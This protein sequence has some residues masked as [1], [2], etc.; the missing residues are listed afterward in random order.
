[1][2][3]IKMTNKQI[4]E[5]VKSMRDSLKQK[6]CTDGKITVQYNLPKYETK[7]KAIVHFNRPAW[8]K[9]KALVNSCT[10][11][12]GWHGTVTREDSLFT[13]H[14]VFVFPQRV[15]GTT[16]TSD[17]TKYSLWLNEQPDEV[18][19]TLRFHG[20][21]HV[22][23]GVTP[24]GVDTTYQED[25]LQ[26]I[27][28]FYM[29]GIFNKRNQVYLIIYDVENNIIYDD[30]DILYESDEVLAE[31]WAS[32]EIEE[33]LERPKVGR[34][35]GTTVSPR[36]GTGKNARAQAAHTPYQQME[37]PSNK[38]YSTMQTPAEKEAAEKETKS[39]VDT[40]M[41]DAETDYAKQYD[42]YCGY[43]GKGYYGGDY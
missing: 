5:L 17:E 14:D 32:M 34:P 24:S 27:Q 23:M 29:F 13:I 31:E 40:I 41:E 33:K 36:Y 1:M 38:H 20:H 28:D 3:P 22:N 2:R 11:E 6:K 8:D 43:Y 12:V 19:N 16:V 7:E 39:I 30:N 21:S 10:T 15:T 4:N 37:L 25:M 42:N 9:L 26:N 35:A 18:F